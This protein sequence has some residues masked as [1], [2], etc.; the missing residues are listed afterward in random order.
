MLHSRGFKIWITELISAHISART[1]TPSE[2]LCLGVFPRF[3]SSVE[4]AVSAAAVPISV[5]ECAPGI[6]DPAGVK[7]ITTDTPPRRNY[8]WAYLMMRVFRLEC[9]LP[10][11][12]YRAPVLK[13]TICFHPTWTI[14]GLQT[15][16]SPVF[17]RAGMKD[18]AKILEHLRSEE[19]AAL[20]MTNCAFA[21]RAQL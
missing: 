7:V 19:S 3:M 10:T 21:R 4:S 8:A 6:N 2:S 14:L 5:Q 12:S 20:D 17:K 18:W 1:G 9:P 11:S 15:D 16:T 13:I